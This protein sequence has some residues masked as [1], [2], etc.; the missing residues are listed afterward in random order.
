MA[1]DL[2]VRGFDNKLYSKLGEIA[3]ERGVS[4]NS[5]VKDAVD[6]W[7]EQT[8]QI[9]KKHQLILYDDDASLT[10]FLRSM[11]RLAKTGGWFRSHL[12]PPTH[13]GVKTLDSYGWFNGNVH[14]YEKKSKNA[15]NFCVEALG[16]ISKQ[17]NGKFLCCM[18]F[19][20]GDV[21]QKE[22]LLKSLKIEAGYNKTRCKGHMFCPYKT[23][24]ISK[25]RIEDTLKLF[26]EH[27]QIY[28]LTNDSVFKLHVTEENVHKLFLN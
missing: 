16:K 25:E 6:K 5:I 22:G 8:K 1:K 9:P 19:L 24:H 2:L 4:L 7:L 21:A 26:H 14:P 18:D 11:D 12:G 3:S 13:R 10:N 17:A 27:D 23:K 15:A 20:I 28:M